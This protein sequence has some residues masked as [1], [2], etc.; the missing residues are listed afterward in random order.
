MTKSSQKDLSVLFLSYHCCIRCAKEGMALKKRGVKVLFAQKNIA[1]NE[2]V[3]Q[4]PFNIAFFSTQEHL[5]ELLKNM[6]G[7]DLIHV[8]NE[9][10]WLVT[11]AKKARPELPIV[12]DCHDLDSQRRGEANKD[13]IEAMKAADAYFF[14]SKA[15]LEGAAE[16]HQL[17]AE[18]PKSVI[19]SMVG[20]ETI[21]V[22]EKPMPRWRGIVYQGGSVCPTDTVPATHPEYPLYRDYLLF[23]DAMYSFGIPFVM[24]G[25]KPQFIPGYI[26][27]GAVVFGAYEYTQMIANISRYDWGLIGCPH[28]QPQWQKAMPNKLF[29]YLAA[30]IP[31]M[32]LNAKEAG[33][34]VED[35]GFGVIIKEPE[36]VLRY[37]DDHEKYRENVMARRDEFTMEGQTD[38][39]IDVYNQVIK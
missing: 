12:Y 17:P 24:Y 27:H 11:I 28:N 26:H 2:V 29:E 7:F 34:F 38:T 9:P 1:N 18:K 21:Y 36:D 35:N 39:I 22:P 4:L 20:E 15:Y 33:E 30:G 10:D 6:Q 32:S 3:Y 23:A 14:P 5:F 13:E 8:H 37:Y 31:V 16:Y 19:Y 25:V